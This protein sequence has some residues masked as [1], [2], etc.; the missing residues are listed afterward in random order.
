MS[1]PHLMDMMHVS[2]GYCFTYVTSAVAIGIHAME[3]VFHPVN[4]DGPAPTIRQ[5]TK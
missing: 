3:A 5:L 4:L 1:A 2:H